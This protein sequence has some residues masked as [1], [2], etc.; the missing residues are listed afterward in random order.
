[1]R[2]RANAPWWLETPELE[3]LA[4]AEQHARYKADIW[5]EPIE[6]WLAKRKDVSV[7]EV[8]KGALGIGPKEQSR[9]VQMRVANVLT[10]LGY[11]KVRTGSDGARKN[12]Y[13]RP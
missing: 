12:R 3:A 8:L 13:R 4:T 10:N 5:Q 7:S 11:T 2:Y 6:K 9:S 1:V